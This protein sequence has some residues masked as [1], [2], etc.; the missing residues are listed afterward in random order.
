MR[1]LLIISSALLLSVNS[2]D[3]WGATGHRA[4]GEVA[5]KHLSRKASKAIE[6]LLEGESLAFVSTYADEIRS[7]SQYNSYAPWHYVNMPFDKT[8]QDI[9]HKDEGDIV[10]AINH[11]IAVLKNPESSKADQKFFLKLLVHFIGDLHQPMHV[12][13]EE[14]KGGND[15]KMKWFGDNTNLHRVWDS[16]II[17]SYQMSYT[18]LSINLPR[19]TK[20][21]VKMIQAAPLMTWVEESHDLVKGI[22]ENTPAESRL[23]YNYREQYIGLVR[24]QIQKGGL[25]LAAVLNEIFG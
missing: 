16:D 12:G 22:Y 25:R 10:K 23:S 21:E 9:P 17:D 8:Y 1:L 5:S 14:D 20:A 11:C 3:E 2:S 13:R 19:L 18:E 15:I 6:R 24:T 4:I 7:D